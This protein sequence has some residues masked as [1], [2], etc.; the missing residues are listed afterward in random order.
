[1]RST[2]AAAI[3]VLAMLRPALAQEVR[4]VDGDTLQISEMT[5]RLFGIDAPEAGQRCNSDDGGTWS[6]GAEATALMDAL[7]ASGTVSCVAQ[8]QDGYGRVLAVCLVGGH[9]LN[10]TMVER[11]MAWSFRR[12]S[13]KYDAIE[14]A[15]HAA[16]LGV[17]RM[18]TET[19]WDFRARRWAHATAGAPAGC[20]IKGNVNRKGERIYHAPWSPWYE[21]TGVNEAAG[22]RW[23]CSEAEATA[24]GWR[25]PRWGR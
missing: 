8:G 25:A 22:E 2:T 16:R 24:A 19:P 1:V 13:H 11:G 23:F 15:A 9:E 18:E 7:V 5:Y 4:V 12:Y 6:C 21:R 17:W 3:V 10:K 20:P 14:D